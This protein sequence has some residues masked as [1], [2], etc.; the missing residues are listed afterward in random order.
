MDYRTD[1]FAR[2]FRTAQQHLNSK[3]I[4]EIVSLKYRDDCVNG[5]EYSH[6][7]HDILQQE[8][9]LQVDQLSGDFGG[10][11]WLLQDR[12]QSRLI[13]VEHETGLEILGAFGS[14]ASLI[15]LIPLINSAW[16]KIRGRY[17]GHR[18]DY[19]ERAAMEIR[20]FDQNNVLIEEHTST[21]E[22]YILNMTLQDYTALK[23]RVTKLEEEVERLKKSLPKKRKTV[24]QKSKTRKKPT[25]RRPTKP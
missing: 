25:H 23:Q 7:V 19:P 17:A 12:L 14:I 15:A 4:Q 3:A 9:G 5:S 13:L 20:H 21:A 10:N 22:V 24:V 2:R 18:F 8:L 1:S 16:T 6:F 11:A